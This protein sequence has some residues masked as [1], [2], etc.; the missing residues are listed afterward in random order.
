MI[1]LLVLWERGKDPS[2]EEKD[3]ILMS[4]NTVAV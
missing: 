1:N 2:I 3:I 4:E